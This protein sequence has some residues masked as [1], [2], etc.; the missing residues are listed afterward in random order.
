M[1]DYEKVQVIK[2]VI[3]T[4]DKNYDVIYSALGIGL[5][6]KDRN[7]IRPHMFVAEMDEISWDLIKEQLKLK[8]VVPSTFNCLRTIETDNIHKVLQTFKDSGYNKT[9]L[10]KA[11]TS[12]KT[13]G[14]KQQV[15]LGFKL[16][17]YYTYYLCTITGELAWS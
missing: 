10:K 2:K 5:P 14:K 7:T 17:L 15:T 8:A 4:S 1:T 9:V 13:G 16:L 12:V 3:R 11:T 6:K